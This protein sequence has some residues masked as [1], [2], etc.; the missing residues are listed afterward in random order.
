LTFEVLNAEDGKMW[1]DGI[2][3]LG[4]SLFLLDAKLLNMTIVV[5]IYVQANADIFIDPP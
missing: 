1:V 3:R 5:A 4:E 2:L